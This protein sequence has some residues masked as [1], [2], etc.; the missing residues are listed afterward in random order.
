VRRLQLSG[1]L[2]H[3]TACVDKSINGDYND[4]L[5]FN[6]SQQSV[7][8]TLMEAKNDETR[9]IRAFF[10][11]AAGGTGNTYLLNILLDAIRSNRGHEGE[12]DYNKP[13]IGLVNASTCFAATLLKLG[14]TF[15]ST[16]K[17]PDGSEMARVIRYT[18][19][20]VWDEVSMAHTHL[21]IGLD[22]LFKDLMQDD[23]PF[24]G[25]LVV[26][27][28]DFIQNLPIVPDGSEAQITNACLKRS[29][30][31]NTETKLGLTENMRGINR[32]ESEREYIEQDNAL[33][34]AM[35]YGALTNPY[36]EENP[37]LARLPAI[38]CMSV[39]DNEAGMP[40][41]MREIY[42]NLLET[43]GDP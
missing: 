20:F 9:H 25:T 42:G 17:A 23:R 4:N 11:S 1:D 31:W 39:T 35:G 21:M 3:S 33:L 16:A 24:G 6:N 14:H 40:Q 30:L 2:E 5:K 27:S 37:H 41:I 8:D 13:S 18:K 7:F 36:P 29:P 12:E 26:M 15:H 43:N 19:I 28:G 34:L 10:I 22:Y 32:A 38:M